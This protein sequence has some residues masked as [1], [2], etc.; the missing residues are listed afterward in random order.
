MHKMNLKEDQTLWIGI[1]ITA[2][3][4]VGVGYYYYKNR[5]KASEMELELEELPT[6]QITNTTAVSRRFKCTNST[7]P[8]SY[9]TCHKDVKTLQ[10]Y[11]KNMFQADL[12]SFGKNDDG[13]D[14][15]FGNKT[16]RAAKMHL[17]KTSFDTKDIEGMNTALK[18]IKK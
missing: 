3:A 18:M 1:G 8:L 2:F 16:S 5:K 9:G 11:L 15:M 17:Q 6:S 12:G 13:I 14:G 7:Y 4:L 10:T